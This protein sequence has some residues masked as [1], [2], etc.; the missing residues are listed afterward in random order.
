M[1]GP[2]SHRKSSSR[3]KC[4]APKM[5][6]FDLWIL[7]IGFL[8]STV[9]GANRPQCSSDG[10]G[11]PQLD[12]CTQLILK[13]IPT[14]GGSAINRLF[15]LKTSIRPEELTRTQWRHRIELPF[16]RENG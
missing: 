7:V 10:Y 15:S 8:L 9:H 16:L 11:Q 14:V 6:H 3:T 1:T 2:N 5:T 4:I 13:E 12:S